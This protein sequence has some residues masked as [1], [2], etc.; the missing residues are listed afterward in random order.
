MSSSPLFSPS[1]GSAADGANLTTSRST[2]AGCCPQYWGLRRRTS[3]RPRS[4][5]STRR[6]TVTVAFAPSSRL[7]SGRPTRLERPT[8][9]AS[10]PSGSDPSASQQLHHARRRARAPARAR[11]GRAGRR[12]SAVSPS[13][14][15]AGIERRDDRVGVELLG[16]RQLDED[17]VDLVVLVEL[18]DQREQLLLRRSRR[19]ARGR[20][21]RIPTSSQ[22][23]CL[24]RT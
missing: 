7:I 5:R 16:Q 13:T 3:R 4:S 10:L 21:E 14:S 23:S 22:A 17:P 20:T 24:R 12:W 19:R 1:L 6:Q 18:A 11:R 8:I 2:K 15:L 9:T